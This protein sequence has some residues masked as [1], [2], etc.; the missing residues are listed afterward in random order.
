M[1]LIPVVWEFGGKAGGLLYAAVALLAFF[2]APD[3]EAALCF[4]LL[5]GWYPVARPKLQHI[6]QK[7]VRLEVKLALF[8]AALL[9]ISALLLFVFV[10]P[11]LQQEAQSWTA[12]LLVAFFV[13]GNISFLLYDVVL[14]R[15]ADL[16]VRRLRPN[17]FGGGCERSARAAGVCGP[18]KIRQTPDITIKKQRG[19]FPMKQRMCS[20]FLALVL[21]LSLA[22][23]A[24]AAGTMPFT[25]VKE[26]DWFYS[27]VKTM[28]DNELVSGTTPTTFSPQDTVTLGEALK[29]ILN[30]AG[31]T[32][33]TTSGKNW[34][35]GYYQLAQ[36]K[37]FLNS[38]WS[39]GLNDAMNRLQI[40]ELIVN[41]LGVERKQ[42]TASPFTDTSDV[43][44]LILSDHGIFEG[45]TERDGKTYFYPQ[46]NIS[47]AEISTVICRVNEFKKNQEQTP[48]E[49]DNPPDIPDD[50]GT[51]DPDDDNS[52]PT[53]GKYFY[54]QGHKVYIPDN[55]ALRDYD[56][57]LFQLDE[58]GYMHY[59][60]DL[61]TSTVGVDVSRYQGNIDWAQVK[62]SG[63]DFAIL[64]LGYRGYGTG[65][66]VLD[67]YFRQN[68]Q[69]A[70]A[71]G[72]E[73]GVYFFSQ[74]INEAE[75]VEE[76]QYCMDV[77]QNYSIT[78]PIVFDWEPYSNNTNARTNGL[79]DKM[80]TK[81]AVAFCQAVEDGGYESMVY[82]NLSYFYLHFDMSKLAEFPLWLANYVKKTNFRYHFDMWQYSCTGTVPGIKGNVDM[83]IRLIPKT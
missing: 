49:P 34:A 78:Y 58:N 52:K 43:A 4:V 69:D 71:N 68:I 25:D 8:N 76:A 17:Y 50:P 74:A 75:A 37:G 12:L 77:L 46:R 48:A 42:Q 39:L 44:A 79:S 31:Y 11:D 56:A 65:K 22:V 82:S 62:A 63:V 23:P 10:M 7:P 27:Y 80:L 5:F 6:R 57:S 51:I 72:I 2:L 53:S 28:Y 60:S 35:S 81:C 36:E 64:R 21:L 30:A 14:G 24:A 67:T 1:F 19:M 18:Y 33:P 32:A 73:I 29:F 61:Y 13:L 3:K 70:Q 54:Y 20:L 55:I 47:R 59:E 38:S 40:A 26:S 16:Y 66:I 15:I 9:A 83:N 45:T 41:V